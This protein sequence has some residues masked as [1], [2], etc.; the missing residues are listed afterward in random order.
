MSALSNHQVRAPAIGRKW[1]IAAGHPLAADAAND[2]LK[3]GGS[4]VDA[5]IAASATL[6]VVSPQ[7]TTLGGD[8]A[9]L[10]RRA[11]GEVQGY[12]G[13]GWAFGDDVGAFDEKAFSRGPRACVVPGLVDLWRLALDDHGTLP[14]GAL[15]QRAIQIA[16]DGAPIGPELEKYV[17]KRRDE[18]AGEQFFAHMF[19]DVSGTATPAKQPALA[20]T[21][22][23]LAND[24]LRALYEGAPARSLMDFLRSLDRD[25]PESDFHDFQARRVPAISTRYGDWSVNAM[26]P[27]FVGLL[28]LVQLQALANEG[29]PDVWKRRFERHPAIARGVFETWTESIHDL[30][31]DGADAATVVRHCEAVLSGGAA[32]SGSNHVARGGDTAGVV[33]VNSDGEAACLLQSIFQ[34]FGS[35]ICDPGTGIL[36]NNRMLCFEAEGTNRPARRRRPFH[37]LNPMILSG[38]AG[39]VVACCSPGGI[40][41]TTTCSQILDALLRG[42]LPLDRAVDAS[43]WSVSRDAKHILEDGPEAVDLP[44]GVRDSFD[45]IAR[46]GASFYF[47]SFKIA[48]KEAGCVAAL[49]DQRREAAAKAI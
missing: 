11:S 35:R 10:V 31:A 33:I 16:Q 30:W 24:G 48:L 20:D 27:P 36:F 32:A 19:A 46:P 5:V 6:T 23:R 12:D 28:G 43:R 41:Q 8:G 45:Q 37:T 4:L 34:P 1:A 17:I 44:Q 49:A 2:V 25:V 7:A 26:P 18:F 13:A 39:Q 29:E 15:L 47:G 40:S 3:A 9:L 22:K 21:L 42:L 14:V 38:V